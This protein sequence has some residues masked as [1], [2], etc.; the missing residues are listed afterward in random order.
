M[1]ETE[2]ERGERGRSIRVAEERETR[3]LN[4]GSVVVGALESL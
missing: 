1:G 2:V 4:S 3:E